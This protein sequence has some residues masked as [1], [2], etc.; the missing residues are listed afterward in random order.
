[1]KIAY[2]VQAAYKE[3]GLPALHQDSVASLISQS[4]GKLLAKHVKQLA[5]HLEQGNFAKLDVVFG[6]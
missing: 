3:Y 6:S 5:A 4:S 2:D 1:M